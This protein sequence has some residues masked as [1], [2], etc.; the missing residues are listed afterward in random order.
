MAPGDNDSCGYIRRATSSQTIGQFRKSDGVVDDRGATVG[1]IDRDGIV[2]RGTGRNRIGSV[3]NGSVLDN[4][5][6]RIASVDSPGEG[7]ALL[8]LL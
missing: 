5:G 3:Q 4:T 6:R 8:L 1:R 2:H 7:A